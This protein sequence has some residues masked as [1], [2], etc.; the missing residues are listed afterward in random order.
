MSKSDKNT[1]NTEQ[2]NNKDIANTNLSENEKLRV[3]ANL[4]LD[5]LIQKYINNSINKNDK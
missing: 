1:Q 4:I 5:Q 3:L 2:R